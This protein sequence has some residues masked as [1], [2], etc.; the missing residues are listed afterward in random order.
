MSKVEDVIWQ[1][2]E[3]LC[4]EEGLELVDVEFVKEGE[5]Y[6]RI[7]IDTLDET[8]IGLDQ[9]ETISRKLNDVLDEKDPISQAYRLEVSSPGIERPLK[10]ESDFV[11]FQGKKICVRFFQPWNGNKEMIGILGEVTPQTLT[12]NAEQV[13]EIPRSEISKVNLVWD[14]E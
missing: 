14:F 6:L 5:W 12:L 2:T 9:C 8:K 4:E 3:P 13:Y 1:L 10:K 11:R 7:F